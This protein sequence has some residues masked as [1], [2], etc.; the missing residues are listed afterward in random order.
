MEEIGI[1]KLTPK[2][3]E[4]LCEIAE[5]AAR[6][7][8]LS[9]IPQKQVSILNITV[10]IEGTKPV[11]VNVDIDLDLLPS[12]KGYNP[13]SLVNEATQQAFASVEEHLRNIACKSTK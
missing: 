7:H 8:I 12:I 13:K 6:R 10:D 3:V 2:Q 11:T 1:P 9:K 4:E 5:N